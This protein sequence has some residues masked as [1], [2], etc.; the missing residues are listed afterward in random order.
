M[1]VSQGI[2]EKEENDHEKGRVS[3]S[4]NMYDLNPDS[5]SGRLSEAEDLPVGGAGR[6]IREFIVEAGK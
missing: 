6:F 5:C 3:E 1:T 2:I 4:Q